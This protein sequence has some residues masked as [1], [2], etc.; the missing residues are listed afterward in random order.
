M[1]CAGLF[2]VW[3]P[4]HLLRMFVFI[5]QGN[6]LWWMNLNCSTYLTMNPSKFFSGTFSPEEAALSPEGHWFS[7]WLTDRPNMANSC[8]VK[9]KS[10]WILSKFERRSK[11]K[12][13]EWQEVTKA[14]QTCPSICGFILLMVRIELESPFF[15]SSKILIFYSFKHYTDWFAWSDQDPCWRSASRY[16]TTNQG[17]VDAIYYEGNLFDFSR[18]PG[19][20]RFSYFWRFEFSK[21][22]RS[23]W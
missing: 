16:W 4:L 9:G 11:L 14:F 3:E 7:S 18:H 20:H 5:P 22:S 6:I 21:T 2:T 13:T 10:L 8:I 19:K 15:P 1:C 17:H 23:R 12:L